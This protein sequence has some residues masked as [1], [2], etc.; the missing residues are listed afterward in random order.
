[1]TNNAVSSELLTHPEKHIFSV[2][3]KQFKPFVIIEITYFSNT[4]IIL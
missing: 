2:H 3:C 1:M 4:D